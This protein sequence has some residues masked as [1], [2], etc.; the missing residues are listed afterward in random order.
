MVLWLGEADLLVRGSLLYQSETGEKEVQRNAGNEH[1]VASG[2][3]RSWTR[4]RD[5]LA[6]KMTRRKDRVQILEE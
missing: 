2:V 6:R 4:V 1:F 5:K 3:R